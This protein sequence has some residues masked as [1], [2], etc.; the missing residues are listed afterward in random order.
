[1]EEKLKLKI[2]KLLDLGMLTYAYSVNMQYC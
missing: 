1:M 2:L